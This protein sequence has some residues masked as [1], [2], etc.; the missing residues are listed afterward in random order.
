M[1][2]NKDNI[3]NRKMMLIIYKI[4]EGGAVKCLWH[5]N[6]KRDREKKN[7]V[8]EKEWKLHLEEMF[9]REED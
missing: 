4:S 6:Q 1:C 7:M 2:A 3:F 5:I 9:L 8:L